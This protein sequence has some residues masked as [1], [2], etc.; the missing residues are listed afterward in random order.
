MLIKRFN[1]EVVAVTA[2]ITVIP[3]LFSLVSVQGADAANTDTNTKNK[4][5]SKNKNE[6]S[7]KTPYFKR[8]KGKLS[9]EEIKAAGNDANTFYR[10]AEQREKAGKLD[11]AKDLYYKCAITRSDVWGHNDSAVPKIAIKIG[12]IELKQKHPDEA[13]KWFRQ[14]L[15]AL[16]K[17]YGSGDGELIPVLQLL[18]QLEASEK[19]HDAASSYYDHILRLEERKYGDESAQTTPIRISYIEEL[20]A[21]KDTFEAEKI[22]K[23]GIEI[24]NKTPGSASPNLV[25]LQQL[26]ASAQAA[27]ASNSGK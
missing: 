17:R 21:D 9:T 8:R 3:S 20:L 7:L 23:K 2:I 14:A 15:T 5:V 24:E 16:S 10:L 27:R 19:K 25:R 4:T 6:V 22:A 12:K 13:R 1:R 26:L 11:Q 18:A